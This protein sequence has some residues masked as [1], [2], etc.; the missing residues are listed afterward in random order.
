MRRLDAEG[1]GDC[2]GTGFGFGFGELRWKCDFLYLHT[3]SGLYLQVVHSG[4]RSRRFV[5]KGMFNDSLCTNLQ[6]ILMLLYQG[7]HMTSCESFII[8]SC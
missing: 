6:P 7:T 1:V 5:F 2:T 8:N 4:K 3:D